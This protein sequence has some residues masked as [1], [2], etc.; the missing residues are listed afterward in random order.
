VERN[1]AQVQANVCPG[2]PELV[3]IL[4]SQK[5]LLGVATGNLER[6]G[7][8]KIE[9]GSLRNYFSFGVFSDQTEK[10]EDIFRLGIAEVKRRLGPEA[11]VCVVG[12]T[13]AD[14]N[15]AKAV[16]VPVIAVATGIYTLEQ[17]TEFSPDIAV[18]SCAELLQA[19]ASI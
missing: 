10:R 15:A 4:H 17:L 9:A 13:P 5:K 19:A 16:G 18:A 1:R 7:W 6:I 3:E 8:I 14:I 2:I 12:D 11:S